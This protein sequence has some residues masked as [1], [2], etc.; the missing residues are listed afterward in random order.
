MNHLHLHHHHKQFI[1]SVVNAPSTRKFKSDIVCLSF[2][3]CVQHVLLQGP[4]TRC[5]LLHANAKPNLAN[6]LHLLHT[7]HCITL[8]MTDNIIIRHTHTHDI[9]ITCVFIT[10][11]ILTHAINS[12][13]LPKCSFLPCCSGLHGSLCAL[14]FPSEASLPALY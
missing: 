3:N 4:Y 1:W 10:H 11:Y 2:A 8:T 9:V 7:T 13:A 5:S 12:N 6:S 14:Q